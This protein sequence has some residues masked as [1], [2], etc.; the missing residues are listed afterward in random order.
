MASKYSFSIDKLR[1]NSSHGIILGNIRPGSLVLECG[2]SSGYMTK[3]MKEKLQAEVCIVELNESDFREAMHFASDGYCG[4]LEENGWSE[5]YAGKHF[6]YILFADVLEHLR[7][8]QEV[9]C[10]ATELLKDNG[11]VIASIPNVGHDDIMLN[12]LYNRWNY[13]PLGLLD[14]THIRFWA[15]EN[16]TELFSQADL[17]VVKR[18]YVPAYGTEQRCTEEPEDFLPAIALICLRQYGDVY[19]FIC[20]A[21]KN[22]YVATSNIS[23]V[24]LYEQR[25]TAYSTP[26]QAC[27]DYQAQVEHQTKRIDAQTAWIEHQDA[28]IREQTARIE[29]QDTSLKKQ[30]D[31]IGQLDA[32]IREQRSRAEEQSLFI[33]QQQQ[34]L[35]QQSSDLCEKSACI[36][37][38]S[39][40]IK[41]Q[42]QLL[43]QQT[44]SLREK[45]AFI[46]ERESCIDLLNA[47]YVQLQ[48]LYARLDHDYD[49]VRAEYDAIS[50]AFF[51]KVTAPLRALV[52]ALK[53]LFRNSAWAHAVWRA[54]KR[55]KSGAAAED[56]AATE[57]VPVFY[58]AGDPITILTTKHTLFVARLI[59]NALRKIDV[60]SRILT[61]EPETY[62]EEVHIVI[63]PQIFSKTP[64]RYIAFQMEQ[65][66]SSRWLNEEYFSRLE[67]SY[68][69]L[70]YSLVNI[71]YFKKIT[72][73]GKNFYYLPIDYL[74]GL[75]TEPDKYKYDVLFYGDV[76]NP[77]RK[78]YLEQLKKRFS[79]RIISEV[80]GDALYDE[81]RKARVVVNI[82][83]YE[84]AMLETTRIYEVLS[85]GCSVV[86]SERSSDPNEEERLEGV[87]D[88]VAE[89]DVDAMIERVGYWLSHEKERA[90]AVEANT[91]LLSERASAFEYFFYRF[92]LAQDW[93]NFDRF[94]ELSGDFVTFTSNRICLSL[95][96][97]TDRREAFDRDNKYGFEVI[98]GLRHSRG[99]T[100]CGLSYKFIM[101]RAKDQGLQDVLVCE[102]DVLFP[103]D[104][105][106]RWEK[107]LKYLKKQEE[108]DI[109]QGLMAD[110]GRVTVSRVDRDYGQTFVHMDHMISMVF[111]YYRSSVY[112]SLINWDDTNPD[113][114]TN[115]IDRALEARKLRIIA[116]APFLVGHKEDLPSVIWGFQ[117]TQYS[118]MIERSSEKLMTL[119]RE[120]EEKS[121]ER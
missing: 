90:A 106:E 97:A 19:Q 59:E 30:D 88:F 15:A 77:R 101:K 66:V 121:E 39:L 26:V 14:N 117:N 57:P 68:S 76:N 109:F 114:Q 102:D 79:V 86:V 27:L 119:A 92:L 33:K 2:S 82:H 41:Q 91:K 45:S 73:Y 21:Q 56:G 87:V 78:R 4:N 3:Y 65:T 112:D 61:E 42:Q 81:L 115:T 55:I 29:N 60:D 107:C 8:P 52:D 35:E 51:W 34:L 36:E 83:Y 5:Y 108:W 47:K 18:D 37:E 72:Q 93:L 110:I 98:P 31:W 67:N 116:V 32:M 1:E 25:R 105:E 111:N 43:E 9:L 113:V 96:E 44:S 99:W 24:D 23:F 118:D 11:T 13:Q 64:G 17:A 74:P 40:C 20:F 69:V 54:L 7:D 104:F 49:T 63:C 22:D 75:Q 100:G 62:G 12:L 53:H 6:D 10:R 85:L 16:L 71:S 95:P 28:V 70:D 103:N 58:H 48:T 120:F 80:F 46:E 84:N 94:Y 89:N 38:Q 50:N